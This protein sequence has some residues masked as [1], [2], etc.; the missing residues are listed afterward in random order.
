[1]NY[2]SQNSNQQ[3]VRVFKKWSRKGYAIFGSLGNVVHIGR[4]SVD[5]LQWIGQL[6]FQIDLLLKQAVNSGIEEDEICLDEI[7]EELLLALVVK[8]D[9]TA[10]VKKKC[11]IIF[12]R[13][14]GKSLL[15]V[16]IFMRYGTGN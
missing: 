14:Q 10:Y 5:L 16:F 8:T 3:S 6:L 9:A 7:N 4:L 12:N 15:A 11:R 13:Q 2:L 1:M